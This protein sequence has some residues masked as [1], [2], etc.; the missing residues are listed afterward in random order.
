MRIWVSVCS[1]ERCAQKP[2]F[3]ALVTTHPSISS[4]FSHFIY[5][6]IWCTLVDFSVM[7]INI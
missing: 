7:Y 1:T 2:F 3:F 4:L 5:V 6:T